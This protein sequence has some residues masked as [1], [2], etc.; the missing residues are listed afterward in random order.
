MDDARARKHQG[1]E[2]SRTDAKVH[3]ARLVALRSTTRARGVER[4]V[5]P[6]ERCLPPDIRVYPSRDSRAAAALDARAHCG[7]RESRVWCPC[8]SSRACDGGDDD[9]A[10]TCAR[11]A[12]GAC[13][14]FEGAR[15]GRS[16]AHVPRVPAASARRGARST[17]CRSRATMASL[18][19]AARGL[20][21]NAP[22]HRHSRRPA[23]VARRCRGNV[24]ARA[25][26]VDRVPC[27]QS[28]SRAL[29]SACSCVSW[30]ARRSRSRRSARAGIVRADRAHALRCALACR[31]RVRP[32]APLGRFPRASCLARPR[33]SEQTALRTCTAARRSHDRGAGTRG[34]AS[35][36]RIL[37][38]LYPPSGC[39][40][41]V[42][43][44]RWLRRDARRARVARAARA[45]GG[46][47]QVARRLW[48]GRGG[49]ARGRAAAGGTA[50]R[51]RC[52]RPCRVTSAE[53]ALRG[54]DPGG[55]SLGSAEQQLSFPSA[56]SRDN[57]GRALLPGRRSRRTL[58]ALWNTNS[59]AIGGLS[60][61]HVSSSAHSIGS[62]SRVP[63][64]VMATNVQCELKRRDTD[65]S[66]TAV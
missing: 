42:G 21:T 52:A 33:R 25:R 41:L 37:R 38:A 48:R 16:F 20:R 66:I 63:N 35:R 27:A 18:R 2:S 29:D 56:I 12:A 57:A 5:R 50:A 15:E 8:P 7:H 34:L 64:G 30:R 32:R 55:R 54:S 40:R 44:R 24:H 9:G 31:A 10:R 39:R 59:R 49:R 62:R 61:T 53:G 3:A 28:R 45:A 23:A 26:Q 4:A 51:G 65:R 36:P 58:A 11:A 46:L 17:R 43:H 13:S 47:G 19:A 22:T 6:P 60:S 14:L 1:T